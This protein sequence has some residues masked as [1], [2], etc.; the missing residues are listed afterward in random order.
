MIIEVGHLFSNIFHILS[1][2]ILVYKMLEIRRFRRSWRWWQLRFLI[3]SSLIGLIQT[4][5]SLMMFIESAHAWPSFS[6][7]CNIFNLCFGRLPCGTP[8]SHQLID[9]TL[10]WH[11]CS[12]T[13]KCI[14]PNWT[15]SAAPC[16]LSKNM[17]LSCASLLIAIFSWGIWRSGSS[18][19]SLMILLVNIITFIDIDDDVIVVN[20]CF[21]G[22]IS[23]RLLLLVDRSNSG[24]I[25]IK[26]SWRLGICWICCG[27]SIPFNLTIWSDLIS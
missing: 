27:L 2:T 11:I 21:L 14:I 12:P 17:S 23:F 1:E 9:H 13:C 3:V 8:F 20:R 25:W 6:N 18:S 19:G 16:F 5:S 7:I 15:C 10:S 4:L 26:T 24:L 22:K